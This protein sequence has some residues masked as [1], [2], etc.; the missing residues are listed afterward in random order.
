MR[1]DCPVCLPLKHAS[2]NRNR[3]IRQL[4][5]FIH[6]IAIYSINGV[7][8]NLRAKSFMLILYFFLYQVY[9]SISQN[10]SVLL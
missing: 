5:N 3:G 9:F 2:D 4:I 8:S 7:I 10:L 6:F 1:R